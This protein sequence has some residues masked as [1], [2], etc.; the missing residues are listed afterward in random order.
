MNLAERTFAS[1]RVCCMADDGAVETGV[2]CAVVE[3]RVMHVMHADCS[4]SIV[5]CEMTSSDGC[6]ADGKALVYWPIWQCA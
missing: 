2:G 3:E 4:A 1:R 5:R 6:G